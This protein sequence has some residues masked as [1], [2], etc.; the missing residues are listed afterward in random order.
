[1]RQLFHCLQ[2]YAGNQRVKCTILRKWPVKKLF[3]DV[4]NDCLLKNYLVAMNRTKTTLCYELLSNCY[5]LSVLCSSLLAWLLQTLKS[6]V[7]Y[8][9]FIHGLSFFHIKQSHPIRTIIDSS[10]LN[11]LYKKYGCYGNMGGSGHAWLVVMKNHVSLLGRVGL[12][13][14][15]CLGNLIWPAHI[16]VA[17]IIEHFRI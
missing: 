1:M 8:S 16:I 6:I 7:F 12:D 9:L 3:I 5:L 11:Y 15:T 14:Q 2:W 4:A 17:H 13:C 10:D